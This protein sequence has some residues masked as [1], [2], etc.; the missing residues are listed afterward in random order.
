[1]SAA[2]PLSL[3]TACLAPLPLPGVIRAAAAAGYDGLE[4]VLGI[5][6]LLRGAAWVRRVAASSS[7]PICSVHQPLYGI[8]PW[9]SPARVINDT[10]DLALHL[11]AGVVVL[12]SPWARSW[13][14][15]SA[16][17]WLAALEQAQNR[18][19]GSGAQL[20]V[21]NQSA[22][23]GRPALAVLGLLD[24]LAAF[25]R[26]RGLGLTYDTCHAGTLGVDL[27]ADL[28]AVSDVLANV[29]LSDYCPAAPLERLPVLDMAAANHQMP[30]EGALDLRQALRSLADGGY[31]GPITFEVS[32]FALQAWLPARRRARLAQAL[33]FAREALPAATARLADTRR[34]PSGAL[35]E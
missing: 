18:M 16:S 31:H 23:A 32:P 11:G 26:Q 34:A 35:A 4:L 5:D 6:R 12:H 17:D 14:D 19:V 15:A 8:G 20:T 1:M 27:A 25:C 9:R 29:H 13:D 24:E 2:S 7:V 3:S 22:H 33:A 10:V 30:G 28:A 21:E